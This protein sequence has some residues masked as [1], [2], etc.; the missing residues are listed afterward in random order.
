[1][2]EITCDNCGAISKMSLVQE[3]YEG[4]Y[5]C[6]KCRSTF[7]IKIINNEL[8]SCRPVS[9]EEFERLIA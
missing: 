7:I 6:W 5:R 1:M 9:A 8:I 3:I 4:P 2:L